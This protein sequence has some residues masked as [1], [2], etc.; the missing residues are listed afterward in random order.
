M[1]QTLAFRFKHFLKERHQLSRSGSEELLS[2]SEYYG[3]APRSAVFS[4]ERQES[5]AESL[6]GYRIVKK[7]DL[8]MNY[9][10]AWKGA[11]GISSYDGIVSPAYSVFEVDQ[12]IV[13]LRFLHHRTRSRDMQGTFKSASKGIMESRLRLYPE[14][15]LSLPVELPS[16]GYQRQVSEYLDEKTARIDTLVAKKTR[17][18]ELLKEKR[19]AVITKAVTKGLDDSVEMKDSGVDSIG[20]FPIHWQLK[21][22]KYIAKV[23]TGI[24]KG[25]DHAGKKTISVPYLR[26]ANVQ[27]GHLLLEDVA[28]MEIPQ[29]DL[30]RYSLKCGDVLMN[31]GGDFDKLGRG[32]VWNDEITPCVHQNHVFAVRPYAVSSE[33]LNAFTSSRVAQFYFMGRSKQSTNLASISSTNL[34]ELPVPVPPHREQVLIIES[35]Q[36]STDKL[37]ALTARTERSIEFL[38]EHRAAL[39]TAAVTGKIDVREAA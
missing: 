17:F 27:D 31:E 2:V 32:H 9:M 10:L 29:E 33:W 34:M 11:Y 5:R 12:S 4:K 8:V 30:A 23:Q 16:L 38:K 25:K 20:F 37:T 18:I 35:L 21:R 6:E 7:G 1:I 26:V 39:I 28:T 3:V 13:D 19:Q 22:L 24:A 36:R 14:T 15:L